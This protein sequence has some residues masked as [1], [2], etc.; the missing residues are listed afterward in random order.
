MRF[1]SILISCMPLNILRIFLYRKILNYQ[2]D[3]SSKISM[4]N[5]ISCNKFVGKKIKI[6]ILNRI[7]VDQ[8]YCEEG[9]VIKNL[10]RFLFVRKITL[11]TNATICSSNSFIG[12]R[13][14]FSPYEDTFQ[15]VI[16][17]DTIITNSHYFDCASKITIGNN[18]VFGG[19]NTEVWTHGFDSNRIMI[20][21]DVFIGNDIYIGSGCKILQGV[22]IH[23]KVTIGAGAIISKSIR[24]S[25]FYVSSQLIRK[26]NIADYSKHPNLINYNGSG[27]IR[28]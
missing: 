19:R 16:G 3:Y 18:V 1:L 24:E 7:V 6:G 5:L 2:I 22:I 14:F 28:K 20:L 27:F 12:T 21:G 23:D 25:G 13:D 17:K 26:S 8:M 11:R 4:F 10:N 9:V 15:I